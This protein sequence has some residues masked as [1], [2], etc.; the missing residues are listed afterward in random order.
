MP[1]VKEAAEQLATARFHFNALQEMNTPVDLAE[2]V[3]ADAR[4]ELAKSALRMAQSEYDS[5]IQGLTASE[6]L[7]LSRGDLE[8]YRFPP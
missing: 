3:K 2:R 5:I 4:M 7:L 1:S 8:I 6:L